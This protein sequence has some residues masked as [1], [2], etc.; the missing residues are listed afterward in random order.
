MTNEYYN[1]PEICQHKSNGIYNFVCAYYAKQA[2]GK[3]VCLFKNKW[4]RINFKFK[5]P[6]K[7]LS[8]NRDFQHTA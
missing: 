8:L 6:N 4:E 3:N 1:P 5:C 2:G 7:G